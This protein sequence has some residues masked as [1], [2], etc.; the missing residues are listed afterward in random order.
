MIKRNGKPGLINIDKSGANKAAIKD[1]NKES[2][3]R[4]K[5]RQCKYLNN[6]VEADHRFVKRKMKQAMGFETFESA[7]ATIKGI[8][9]WR[10]IKKGQTKW[11]GDKSPI[12][13]FYALAA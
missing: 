3:S 6:I 2:N 10:M 11:R 13:I 5:V 12:D 1:Y 7:T 4:I 9:M 8:E